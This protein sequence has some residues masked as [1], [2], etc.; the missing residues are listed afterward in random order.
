MRFANRRRM[1]EQKIE[2]FQF[3]ELAD[4]QFKIVHKSGL[5]EWLEPKGASPQTAVPVRIFSPQGHEISLDY[6]VVNGAP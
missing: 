5:V 3:Y 6:I 4:N 1:K 2:N